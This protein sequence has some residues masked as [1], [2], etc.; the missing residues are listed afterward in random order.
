MNVLIADIDKV[1]L[2]VLSGFV[3][4]AAEVMNDDIVVLPKGIDIFHDVPIE[5]LKDIRDKLNEKIMELE[6]DNVHCPICNADYQDITEE[7]MMN[8]KKVV[9]IVYRC[10]QCKHCWEVDVSGKSIDS[11]D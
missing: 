9:S 6:S 5:W 8:N 1:P 7:N 10:A 2:D 11:E 4:Q 3:K